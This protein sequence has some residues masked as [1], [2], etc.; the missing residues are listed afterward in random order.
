MVLCGDFV[1]ET[2]SSTLTKMQQQQ[3]QRQK[4]KWTDIEAEKH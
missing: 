4:K 3:Q 2:T 1:A